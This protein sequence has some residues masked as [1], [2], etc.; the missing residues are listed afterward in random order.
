MN[1]QTDQ[2]WVRHVHALL[3][4]IDAQCRRSFGVL[5][6]LRVRANHKDM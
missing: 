3:L 2:S 4:L 1:P 6:N 5:R